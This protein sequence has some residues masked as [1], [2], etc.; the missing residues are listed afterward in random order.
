MAGKLLV[1]GS[2]G[3]GRKIRPGFHFNNSEIVLKI[4]LKKGL[5]FQKSAKDSDGFLIGKNRTL[6]VLERKK[7]VETIVEKISVLSMF[8]KNDPGSFNVAKLG[9]ENGGFT[10]NVNT[11][12]LSDILQDFI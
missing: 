7:S 2:F 4:F 3:D 11:F 9:I 12:D 1:V 6:V 10:Q 5:V 8:V